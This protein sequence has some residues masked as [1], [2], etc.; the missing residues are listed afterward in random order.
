MSKKHKKRKHSFTSKET[1]EENAK[2]VLVEEKTRKA[3]EEMQKHTKKNN[4]MKSKKKNKIKRTDTSL[5]PKASKTPQS[6]VEHNGIAKTSNNK[7]QEIGSQQSKFLGRAV[8]NSVLD[9]KVKQKEEIIKDG[10][11]LVLFYQYVEP[12]WS[13]SEHQ[14]ALDYATKSGDKFGLTGRMRIAK[15]GFN[16]T[17]TGSYD[18]V[19]DWCAALRKWCPNNFNNTEFKF[20]DNLPEGQRFPKLH[21]FSVDEIVNYGLAGSRAPPIIKYGGCHLE[22]DDYHKKMAE[23]DTVIIDVRN[24]Y[25]ANIGRFEPPSE[26]AKWLDPMMRKSTEFPVW[27]D[28]PETK[29]MLRG[30]QV[31]M[32]CT[33][34][35]RCERASALLRQKIENEEDTKELGIKGVYQLQGGI[36]KY[37]KEF[38]DG[39]KISKISLK[40]CPLLYLY[41]ALISIL[42]D[43]ILER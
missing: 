24:H 35:I 41:V 25:E 30:K 29:E 6:S 8:A 10:V 37:F 18:G 12:P 34:G 19:R 7:Q 32:Y 23:N 2:I 27:L 17:L 15:E 31:L 36:D 22:P 5:I 14:A 4:K 43:R 38:P 42:N 26:G 13:A 11:T 16:C 39:G 28:K 33:G 3:N 9:F 21:A 1:P 20:T 40:C